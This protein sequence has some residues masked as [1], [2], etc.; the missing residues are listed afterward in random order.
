MTERV[1]NNYNWPINTAIYSYF[2][3]HIKWTPYIYPRYTT[4]HDIEKIR[5]YEA[6]YKPK[7]YY[8]WAKGK[9]VDIW[10]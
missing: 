6:L 10:V 5:E 3:E 7:F 4:N 2:Q 8:D 1:T 9:T